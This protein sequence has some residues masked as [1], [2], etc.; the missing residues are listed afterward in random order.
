MKYVTSNRENKDS[1]YVTLVVGRDEMI[2]RN[3]WIDS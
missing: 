2:S 1:D 3:F